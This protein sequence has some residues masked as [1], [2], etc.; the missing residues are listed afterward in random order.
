M[1]E[2]KHDWLTNINEV[3]KVSN[4][5]FTINYYK[6]ILKP[7]YSIKFLRFVSSISE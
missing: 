3:I 5:G 2:N 7:T 6:S 4:L 1:T